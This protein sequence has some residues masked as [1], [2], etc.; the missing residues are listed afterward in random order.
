MSSTGAVSELMLLEDR[1]LLR[2]SGGTRVQSCVGRVSHDS[3]CGE[4]T[5]IDS[6]RKEDPY[7]IDINPGLP[8]VIPQHVEM[9]HPDLSEV[10]GMVPVEI[11]AVVVLAT[12]HTFTTGMLAVLADAAVAVGY[13]APAV[14]WRC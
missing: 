1:Y 3:S 7:F 10:P 14:F 8:V 9:A 5:R 6:K 4:F 13:V 11:C 12:G 2:V